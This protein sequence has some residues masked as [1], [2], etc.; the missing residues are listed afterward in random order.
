MSHPRSYRLSFV[1]ISVALCL[2]LVLNISSGSVSIPFSATLS[3]LMGKPLEVSS[4]EYILWDYRI[5]KALT[6]LLVGGGLSLSGLLMQTLF[7]NPLAGPFVLGISSGASLGAAL[8]L[9]GTSFISSFA[10]LSFV[11]DVSLTIAA[12]LGSFLVLAVVLTVAQRIRDTMALLVIG[13]MFGSI[14]SALVSV[15]AY[16]TS[17]ESLQRFIFWSFGSVGNLSTQQLSLLTG[18]VFL[19]VLLCILSI[20]ALNAFLLGEHYAQSLGVSLK[21]SR[22]I[23]IIAAGLLAGGITAFAG[24]IVFIG[25]AV[26]HLTRQIFDTMEH[27]VLVPAVF[28][29]GAILMLLCDTLAQLPNSVNVLPINAITSLVG[30]PVVIWLLVRKRKMI[31]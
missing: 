27:R 11:G 6:A 22:W 23:I 18:I 8:L 21:K 10:S 29:Y 7:R 9:M 25:L 19:G 17:A 14:T 26:P 12:S 28:L 31:F 24:P 20:K 30:A 1:L 3:G 16:F 2:A 15:L 4:W 5:P 13:L